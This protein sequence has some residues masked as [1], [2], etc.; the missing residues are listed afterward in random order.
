M[1]IDQHE[2]HE[3]VHF[4]GLAVEFQCGW[5]V[6]DTS[7]VNDRELQRDADLLGRKTNALVGAHRFKHVGNQRFDLRS[8]ALDALALL[9]KRRMTIFDHS[10]NHQ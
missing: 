3:V 1:G 10:Q 8:N 5:P 7:Y 9:P 2:W 6:G 4:S